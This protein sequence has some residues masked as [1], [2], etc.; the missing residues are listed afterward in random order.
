MPEDLKL[1]LIAKQLYVDELDAPGELTW[2]GD[3]YRNP[4]GFWQAL[5][6]AQDSSFPW[7]GKSIPYET[8]DFYHDMII[9]NQRN[10]APA[11]RWYDPVLGRQKIS[12]TELG[13][14]ATEKEAVWMHSGAQPGQ[15]ICI[16]LPLGVKYV[17]SLVTALKMGLTL[18]CLPPQGNQ[19]L[20]TRLEALAPDHIVTEEIYAAMIPAWHNR[21]LPEKISTRHNPTNSEH[22]TTYPSGAVIGLCFDP[23]SETSH[24]PKE[25]TADAAYLCPLRDGMLALGMRPG[26]VLAAPGFHFLETQ[27]GLLLAVLLNGGTYLH[28]DPDGVA[29]NP[30]QLTEHPIHTIGISAQ[31]R[32]V[33][34]ARPP[35]F[36]EAWGFWF[37]DPAESS[38]MEQWHSFVETLGLKEVHCGNMK[39][40]AAAGGCSLFSIKRRGRPHF[41]MLPS[42]GVPWCLTELA[43]GDQESLEGYGLFSPVALGRE[44]EERT[45]TTIILAKSKNECMFI[46]S[47]G[48]GRAARNYPREEILKALQI[49]PYG[50]H[51]TIVEVA[52]FAPAGTSAFDLLVFTGGKTGNHAATD[53]QLILHTI[54]REMGKEFLP[55]RIRFFSLFPRRNADNNVDHIWCRDQYLTGGLYRKSK[56]EVYGCLT[57]LRRFLQ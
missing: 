7:P 15:K 6:R 16:I 14:S 17:T 45:M 2:L 19:F 42:A 29:K 44:G 32:D 9:R 47:R 52:Q 13:A 5:R 37:R 28:I 40:H 26:N 25:L 53:T 36:S 22:S 34:I 50:L 18:S 48:P 41:N 35:S 20:Q 12:Y 54:E 49:L 23:S 56:N 3:S 8:Y 38:D 46:G 21:I 24:V 51:C 33:L 39:W 10:T 57:Q 30:E 27:P 1:S 4:T 55:D 31:M 43:G 11:L